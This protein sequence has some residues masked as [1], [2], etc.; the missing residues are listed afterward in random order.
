MRLSVRKNDFGYH[1]MAYLYQPYLDGKSISN[2]FTADEDRGV[3]WVHKTD[4]DGDVILNLERTCILEE[5]LFGNVE[6]KLN[7]NKRRK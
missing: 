5:Q 6:L 2:C 1:K 3:V 4:K 7:K